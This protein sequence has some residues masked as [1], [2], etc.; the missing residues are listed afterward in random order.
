V[1]KCR[2]RQHEWWRKCKERHDR[3]GSERKHHECEECRKHEASGDQERECVREFYLHVHAI[4]GL[5]TCKD[6]HCHRIVAVSGPEIEVGDRH[7]HIVKGRTT[8][9]DNHWHSFETRSDLESDLP[10]GF[11]THEV[12]F[13]TNIVD[14]HRHFFAGFTQAVQEEQPGHPDGGPRS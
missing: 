3:P 9:E 6:K 1:C 2:R 7:Y 12:A 5:V 11:H 4:E 8:W 14:E 10:N 13:W